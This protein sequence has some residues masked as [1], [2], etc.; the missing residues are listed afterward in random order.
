MCLTSSEV[1]SL[2]WPENEFQPCVVRVSRK[3]RLY[4]TVDFHPILS[5]AASFLAV[6][7][8]GPKIRFQTNYSLEKKFKKENS[9]L[10]SAIS[11]SSK[12]IVSSRE[13][14]NKL[15]ASGLPQYCSCLSVIMVGYVSSCMS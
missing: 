2:L 10:Y 3:Q 13:L 7:Y 1:I 15:N 5:M 9:F 4:P 14:A 8:I 11:Y 6:L 12:K